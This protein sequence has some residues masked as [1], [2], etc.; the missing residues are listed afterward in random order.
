MRTLL[1]IGVVVGVAGA[2]Y[3]YLTRETDTPKDMG[4]LESKPD[5]ETVGLCCATSFNH[6]QTLFHGLVS[7]LAKGA[8]DSCDSAVLM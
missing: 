5:A 8:F 2:A 1:G 6:M 3:W 7:S 4:C